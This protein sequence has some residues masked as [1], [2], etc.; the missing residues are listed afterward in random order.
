MSVYDEDE[1][2]LKKYNVRDGRIV[3]VKPCADWNSPSASR[4]LRGCHSGATKEKRNP[5]LERVKHTK[6]TYFKSED[7]LAGDECGDADGPTS[8]D[9]FE[10][11]FTFCYQNR[12]PMFKSEWN[13]SQVRPSSTSSKSENFGFSS[14]LRA[15]SDK[16]LKS[17]TNRIL[18]KLYRTSP[19]VPRKPPSVTA[20]DRRENDIKKLRS[21][22]YGQ[23]PGLKEFRTLHETGERRDDATKPQSTGAL[24][25]NATDSDSAS[26]IVNDEGEDCDSGILVSS[27]SSMVDSYGSTATKQQTLISH[28]RSASRDTPVGEQDVV[29]DTKYRVSADRTVH[30]AARLTVCRE[31]E[32]F[33]ASGRFVELE[34]TD[35]QKRRQRPYLGTNVVESYAPLNQ[36]PKANESDLRT[37]F[38][39]VTLRKMYPEEELGIEIERNRTA[40]NRDFVVANI[41]PES[42]AQRLV[43]DFCF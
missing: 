22:S 34:L 23:L 10:N 43:L 28:F 42:V 31:G 9:N 36:S 30:N 2:T 8:L 37:S 41:L 39:V 29:V 3:M 11:D 38:K 17:S 21:F 15:I 32:N 16:Y 4:R 33:H 40:E 14:R 24:D 7:E 26:N 5:L 18:A 12:S 1:H 27:N 19:S 6:L 13:L 20:S 35:R 25:C